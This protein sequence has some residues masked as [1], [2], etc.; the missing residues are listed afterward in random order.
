MC[1]GDGHDTTR[2]SWQKLKNPVLW[3]VIMPL[4][5]PPK[6]WWQTFKPVFNYLRV[7]G[8]LLC[9][10]N[11]KPSAHVCI[12]ETFRE[13]LR[14]TT[15]TYTFIWLLYIPSSYFHYIVVLNLS[16]TFR[17]EEF[18]V[19][20]TR[21]K[22]SPKLVSNFTMWCGSMFSEVNFNVEW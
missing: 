14:L 9:R 22:L 3:C 13:F 18:Q 4:I 11:A 10:L 20:S 16:C 2:P 5:G 1:T 12:K 7:L 6:Q 17:F 15:N 21:T 19:I 8:K